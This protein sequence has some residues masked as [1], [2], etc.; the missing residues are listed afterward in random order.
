M[1]INNLIDRGGLLY[2]TNDDEPYTGLVFEFYDNGQKR[3]NGRYNNGIKNGKWTWWNMD[4]SM[5]STGTYK[6]DLMN[7]LWKYYYQ[8]GQIHGQGRYID[9]DGGN[10]SKS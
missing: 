7:G 6:N 3:L 10:V 5:D 1:D 9:G 4:G 2:A 8:N